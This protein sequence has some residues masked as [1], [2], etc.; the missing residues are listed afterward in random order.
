MVLR[1]GAVMVPFC[2]LQISTLAQLL[3]CFKTKNDKKYIVSEKPIRIIYLYDLD[4]L[5]KSGTQMLQTRK[6]L[7]QNER[8]RE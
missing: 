8:E 6:V 5:L 2:C 7:E 3:N 1:L 4:C